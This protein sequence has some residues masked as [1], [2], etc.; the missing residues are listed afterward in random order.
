[1]GVEPCFEC[2]AALL[3]VDGGAESFELV[4]CHQHCP[5]A[6]NEAVAE[7]SM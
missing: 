2:P 4:A 1:M 3:V 6:G 5:E 7:T